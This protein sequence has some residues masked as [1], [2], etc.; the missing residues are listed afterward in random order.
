MFAQLSNYPRSLGL[1]SVTMLCVSFLPGI[2][3]LPFLL[4][5]AGT[6]YLAWSLSNDDAAQ[7]QDQERAERPIHGPI[8]IAVQGDFESKRR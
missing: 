7:D 5:A 1:S 8:L 2:P 4:L 3:M 6:G